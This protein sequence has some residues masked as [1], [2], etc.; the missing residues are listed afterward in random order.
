MKISKPFTHHDGIWVSAFLTMTLYKGKQPS[1]RP[2]VTL[3]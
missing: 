2:K 1:F 3:P